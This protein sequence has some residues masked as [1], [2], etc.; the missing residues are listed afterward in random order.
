MDFSYSAKTQ[1]LLPRVRAFMD[2]HVYPNEERYYGELEKCGVWETPKV[3][4]ELK[5][6]A[7][8][9]G[10][11]N[12]FLP[13]SELG[14]GLTNLEYAPLAEEMGRAPWAPEIFNC[15]APDTGNM[16]VLARYG[17]PDQKRAWLAPLLE[18]K[19]RSCFAMTE[20]AAESLMRYLAV[21]LAPKG[22]RINA[23]APSIIETDAVRSLF[24]TRAADLVHASAR[25]NPSGRGIAASDYTSLIRWLASPE[26]EFIQEQV[27]FVNGGAN[28]SA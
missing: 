21:E 23:V 13:E 1:H 25:D 4:E 5:P 22:I 10:L 11:W 17:T 26:A 15:S 3:V 24:G 18:G 7:K 6:A 2:S 27:I 20:P 19:T 9:A 8:A 14:A 16:E 12:L 28:L